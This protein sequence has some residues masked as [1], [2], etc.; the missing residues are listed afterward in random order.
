MRPIGTVS[1]SHKS[2]R[3][4]QFLNC[5]AGGEIVLRRAPCFRFLAEFGAA[6]MPKYLL[7]N[8]STLTSILV[9]LDEAARIAELD[10][11]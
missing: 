7:V 5:S 3:S 10:P 2:L 8:L 11:D 1:N 9:D 4:L 6:A